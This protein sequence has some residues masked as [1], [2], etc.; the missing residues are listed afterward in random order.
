MLYL[1][2]RFTI[3]LAYT[4]TPHRTAPL[5]SSTS[6]SFSPCP[7]VSFRS[8]AMLTLPTDNRYIPERLLPRTTS[9]ITPSH[10]PS[11]FD[12]PYLTCPLQLAPGV[13]PW[14]RSNRVSCTSTLSAGAV[15]RPHAPDPCSECFKVICIVQMIA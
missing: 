7:N 10:L 3:S 2:S 6:M 13:L 12:Q 11:P 9:A 15:R 5:A 14:C 1:F 8:E 4:T